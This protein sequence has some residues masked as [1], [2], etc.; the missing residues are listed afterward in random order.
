MNDNSERTLNLS[1]GPKGKKIAEK[2]FISQIQTIN[3]DQTITNLIIEGR[4]FSENELNA[5]GTMLYNQ[6]GLVTLELINCSVDLPW[7]GEFNFY[8]FTIG[9]RNNTSLKTLNISGSN[10]LA[11]A[12]F[13]GLQNAK[14]AIHNFNISNITLSIRE[15]NSALIDRS[16][17]ALSELTSKLIYSQKNIQIFTAKNIAL[18]DEN[19]LVML[20]SALQ[21]Q[22]ALTN[23]TLVPT[24]VIT[25]YEDGK[26][27]FK[28]LLNKSSLTNLVL[29][30]TQ[31][32]REPHRKE[33]IDTILNA[34]EQNE[35]LI[36]IEF[37]TYNFVKDQFNKLQNILARNLLLALQTS[38]SNNENNNFPHQSIHLEA[39]LDAFKKE[40][41]TASIASIYQAVLFGTYRQMHEIL[42][43]LFYLQ[44]QKTP[45]ETVKFDYLISSALHLKQCQ[46]YNSQELLKRID[47]LLLKIV[48]KEAT[49]E[50]TLSRELISHEEIFP[51][52]DKFE[53]QYNDCNSKLKSNLLFEVS[54]FKFSQVPT[55]KQSYL[56]ED[57]Q[58]SLDIFTKSLT[59]PEINAYLLWNTIKADPS[60]DKSFIKN[61]DPILTQYLTELS[62]LAGLKAPST[63]SQ[64][65]ISNLN[66]ESFQ[67]PLNTG[68]GL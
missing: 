4:R 7:F 15:H 44:S 19:D 22:T 60:I 29:Q 42:G 61:L 47:L 53:E 46:N 37:A 36:Q 52:V 56:W 6:S 67:D 50:S 24:R 5:I 43:I 13:S 63:S 20:I 23:L 28:K 45:W 26:A 31:F 51:N 25:L 58:T 55:D 38:P 62:K 35:K 1:T 66:D 39:A 18:L 48:K 33:S 27:A 59:F 64:T 40:D 41:Y 2:D 32:I 10:D 34:L 65:Q 14:F 9:L 12:V 30:K 8:S 17:A 21:N 49:D 3:T 57:A 68:M 16:N 11:R 54:K